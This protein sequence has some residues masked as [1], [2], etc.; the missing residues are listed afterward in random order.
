M[1][2]NSETKS[3]TVLPIPDRPFTGPIMYDAKDPSSKF[4]P[5]EPLRPPTSAP[6]VLLI[7]LDD[8]GFGAMSR[9]GGP[10]ATP[11]TA[12]SASAADGLTLHAVPR[13]RSLHADSPGV[14]H[15]S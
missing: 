13:L 4:P 7:L 6:N 12:E 2:S 15:R 10:C 8:A 11:P 1:K 9:F 3:R 5:I 14:A